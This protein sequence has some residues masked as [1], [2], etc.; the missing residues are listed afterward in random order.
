MTT[1]FL[2]LMKGNRAK[3]WSSLGGGVLIFV[4]WQLALVLVALNFAP[5]RDLLMSKGE[6]L[7]SSQEAIGIIILLLGGFGPAFV[8][9]LAW[10]KVMERRAF[11]SLFTGVPRFRW[12]LLFASAFAVCALALTLTFVFDRDSVGQI[13]DRLARFSVRDW[14]ILL[15]AYGV[16]ITVQASFEEVYVRGWLLQHIARFMPNAFA[17]I[18]TTAIIFSALHFGHPGYAT[19]VAA[20]IFGLAYGWSALRLNG[21]EA[22]MGAHIANNLVGALLTGQMV[23]G[24]PPTMDGAQ[25][26]LYAAYVLGFLGFVEVWARLVEKPSRA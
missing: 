4:V 20:L 19:Y 6:V 14:L 26:V 25:V 15:A 3:L 9:V 22:A 16:G 12:V 5:A 7:S 8:V 1:N 11:V 24:N 21:L 17:A 10:R 18:V 23:S 13:N 2:D